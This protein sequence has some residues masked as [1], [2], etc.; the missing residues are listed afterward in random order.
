MRLSESG[1]RIKF[2]L[3]NERMCKSV[4]FRLDSFLFSVFRYVTTN[5]RRI[6]I[7]YNTVSVL[8][9]EGGGG[10]KETNPRENKDLERKINFNRI[11]VRH[12]LIV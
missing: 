7:V 3:L 10:R 6:I 4:S 11:T 12:Y 2:S 9:E 1:A 8:G 5:V